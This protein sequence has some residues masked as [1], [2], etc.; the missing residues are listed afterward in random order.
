MWKP[1]A[2]HACGV[3][4]LTFNGIYATDCA[5][6]SIE[7]RLVPTYLESKYNIVGH[8]ISTGGVFVDV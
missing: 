4:R 5:L 7:K 1:W 3:Q 6:S 8:G 2:L